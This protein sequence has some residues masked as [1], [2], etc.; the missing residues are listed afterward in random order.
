MRGIRLSLLCAL[1]AVLTV[2]AGSQPASS[3]AEWVSGLRH[4]GYVIVF[5]HGATTSDKTKDSMSNPMSANNVAERQLTSEGRAQA[6][7]TGESMRKLGIPVGMVLTSSLQRAVD[8]GTLLGFGEVTPTA[9]L[10]EGGPA[11]LPDENNRRAQA[12]R[13]LAA[14]RPPADKNTVIVSHK[15][16]IVAAF[17]KDFSD[18]REGEASIFQPDGQTGYKLIVRVKA[19]EWGNLT[20][21]SN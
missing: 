5:R 13:A 10:T 20:Q 17:G 19:E 15:P 11:S 1:F 9:D 12:F 14:A 7:A 3:Q 6:K 18:V 8:T 21:V 16:N 2:V 4:G